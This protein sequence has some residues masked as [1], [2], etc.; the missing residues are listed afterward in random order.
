MFNVNRYNS[1]ILSYRTLSSGVTSHV[2][3]QLIAPSSGEHFAFVLPEFHP[4]YFRPF[5]Q[6]VRII[7]NSNPVLHS[8]CDPSQLGMVDKLS[9]VRSMPSSKSF[10]KILNRNIPKTD[11]CGPPLNMPLHLD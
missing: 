8:T 5:L 6:L 11:L 9:R 4:V 1:Q 10:L 3:V 7:L 2:C